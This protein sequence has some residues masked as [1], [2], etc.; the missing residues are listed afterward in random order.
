LL[1]LKA[2]AKYLFF[3]DVGSIQAL[4]NA[5]LLGP[6][7]IQLPE[8]FLTYQL[9]IT[10]ILFVLLSLITL[11]LLVIERVYRARVAH[12]LSTDSE[13]VADVNHGNRLLGHVQTVRVAF[14]VGL[15]C[16]FVFLLFTYQHY[17]NQIYTMIFAT[18]IFL[19]NITGT[20]FFGSLRRVKETEALVD[21]LRSHV[22]HT[23]IVQQN[24]LASERRLQEQNASLAS[25]AAMQL[26][27]KF[28][29]KVFIR[30]LIRQSAE[31]LDVARVSVWVYS[32]EK[33]TLEC[34]ALY[35]LATKTYSH[36]HTLKGS[37][38]PHYFDAIAETRVLAVGNALESVNTQELA[39]E[40]LPKQDEQNYAGS[41]AD[42]IRLAF[43]LRKR[44]EVETDF[45]AHQENVEAMIAHRISLIENNAK[46]FRFLVERAPVSILYMNAANEVLEMNPEAERI[47]GYTRDEAIGRR[48]ESLFVPDA[49][50]QDHMRDFQDVMQGKVIQGHD[51]TIKRA[52]GSTIDLSVSRRME[53]DAEGNPVVISIGQ[54]ISQKK[55]LEASLIKAREA[56]EAA[57]RIKSMFVASMSHELRTPLNSIIGFIGV[58]LQGMS[59]K[60]NA[61]QKDQLNRAYFSAKHLL[62]L[63]SD[64][65]DISKIEAGYIEAN[66]ESV[67]VEEVIEEV[68]QTLEHLIV[69]K[70]LAY[71]V[72]CDQSVNIETDRRRFFQAI[73]N[74]VSNAVKY[75]EQGAVKVIVK[76]LKKN[77]KI[78]VEDSGI[79]MDQEGVARLF[80]PFERIDSHLKV[81]TLGTGLGLYL[82]KNILNLI[83]GGDITVKSKLGEGSTFTIVLPY[84][85]PEINM[86]A[87]ASILE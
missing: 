41:L 34:D 22:N 86:P 2:V 80:K 60:I 8:V 42:L 26:N 43:E 12:K 6:Y 78:S 23:K 68:F 81:K 82:T 19:L 49:Q 37:E 40:Y 56:A 15:V 70:D 39:R 14:I 1:L 63:I 7:S 67:N 62:S 4:A 5:N 20:Y 57:D 16:L 75:T 54:D 66:P 85:I 51:V 3:S 79:G 53:L 59:G 46:L 84:K 18:G 48:Y 33:D 58:V 83:L 38:L 77:I 69:E 21:S 44:Q 29:P 13:A 17:S 36:G 32:K 65:I 47:L 61:K 87:M 55:A 9:P 64:V 76:P 45:M 50:Q 73:L 30:Q 10:V 35:D 52:D 25:L 11:L 31:T 28:S 27:K 71:S 24:L 72:H 74:L